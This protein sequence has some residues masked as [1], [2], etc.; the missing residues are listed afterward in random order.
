M[1][2]LIQERAHQLYSEQLAGVGTAASWWDVVAITAS[3]RIQAERYEWEIQRRKQRGI[4]PSGASYIVIPDPGDRRAGSGGATINALR[5][6]GET[7]PEGWSTRRVLLIHSGGDSRRLPQYSLSG[8]LF[9]TLPVETSWGEA[10]T[11]FDE[12]LA[13]STEWAQQITAGV[14]IGSGDVV[15]TFDAA[16]LHWDRPGVCGVAMR[17]PACQG[18]HHGVYVTDERGRVYSFLQKPSLAEMRAAGA[19]LESDAIALDVGLLRFSP[20]VAARLS[21]IEPASGTPAFDLYQHLTMA[22]TGQWKPDPGDPPQFHAVAKALDG[23]PFWC[24][25]VEGD[26][27]HIGTTTLFRR[28]HTERHGFAI[29]SQPD[30]SKGVAINSVLSGSVELQPG[31]LL[32]ECNLAGGVHAGRGSVLHGLEG[33]DGTVEVPE[34]VVA[35]QVAVVLPDGKK[36]VVIR[37]YGVEDDPKA[38]VHAATWFGRPLL[39]HLRTL[40]LD[41]STVWPGIQPVL[42]TLW[43][44]KLF[45]VCSVEEGWACTLWMMKIHSSFD[46]VR[47]S[48]LERLSLADS[49]QFADLAEI[50]AAHSRRLQANW[51]ASAVALAESGADIRPLLKNPPGTSPLAA[52]GRSLSA[53]GRELESLEPTAAASRYYQASLFFAHGGLQSDS[54]RTREAA[55]GMVACAVSAGPRGATFTRPQTWTR[56]QVTVS[57]PARIDL[58]GGWSDT[59][60]FCLDWGGCVLNIGIELEGAYPILTTIRRIEDP[61]VRFCSRDEQRSAE[62]R[63]ATDL[64]RAG[65]PG[66]PFSIARNALQLTGL[67]HADSPLTGTLAQMG[68]GLEIDT[69]VR[70]PMGSGLGA[71]SI[72]AATIIRALA[73]MTG[74]SLSNQELSDRTMDLEQ[75]TT[76]GG[77]WQDQ[78]G[79]ILPGAKFLSSGPGLSQCLRTQEILLSDERE[80]ELQDLLV[81]Y[82][83]GIKRVAKGLLQQVVGRYLAREAA[84]IQV[85][86]SIKTLAMEM[87]YALEHGKWDSLGE[88]L[89]R[90]WALNQILDPNT[91]NAPINALLA[92][93]RP[94]IRGAKLAGAGGGGF[95]MLLARSPEAA[96]EL[97][98][99][100]AERSLSEGGSVKKWAIATEGL[101]VEG[102][103]A[104]RR[105]SPLCQ[106]VPEQQHA[107]DERGEA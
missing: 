83:T 24:S 37:A 19:L 26:F 90:H 2:S 35:H 14:V 78:S 103:W 38:P 97:R 86:H 48:Q 52:V 29:D 100:L 16:E 57:A 1:H 71:S 74:V 20:E 25:L 42:R 66:D 105:H 45:P 47:W 7:A 75:R 84:A 30:P 31:A 6:I 99:H 58:G 72:L 13:R 70:L 67:F 91:T 93:A 60:P 40:D 73:E 11:V 80:A 34:N 10:S 49:T 98:Q 32:L 94:Y 15:L 23:T 44:A 12:T 50:E 64:F 88:L 76:T 55:F 54:E 77:G 17:Q 106:D 69:E 81:L 53:R 5:L 21:A 36:G 27:T 68:G 61:V 89:D 104:S 87:A 107:C 51:C 59:P 39:A 56:P 62:C 9:T 22:L 43:N 85:L 65:T 63:D 92:H 4:L 18:L 95:M 3:S 33:I 101:R 79:G 82:Y 28:I 8:K 41:P 96:T 102:S 46:V